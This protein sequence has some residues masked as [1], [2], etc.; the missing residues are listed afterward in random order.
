MIRVGVDVGGTFTDIVLEHS[1]PSGEQKVYVHKVSKEFS[2]PSALTE[3]FRVVYYYVITSELS[4]NMKYVLNEPIDLRKQL[5]NKNFY[6][7]ICKY[8]YL[9]SG[10][11]SRYSISRNTFFVC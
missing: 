6:S 4:E 5:D 3:R 11:Q 8:C 1:L 9:I 10:I 2:K 7:G